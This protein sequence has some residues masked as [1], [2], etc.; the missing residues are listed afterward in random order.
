S[1]P[2]ADDPR[3]TAEID[4]ARVDSPGIAGKLEDLHAATGQP[5]QRHAIT[6]RR[7]LLEVKIRHRPLAVARLVTAEVG[8]DETGGD[9]GDEQRRRQRGV[10]PGSDPVPDEET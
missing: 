5:C 2:A 9:A 8:S 4:R 1:G 3:P 6:T 10:S 7:H